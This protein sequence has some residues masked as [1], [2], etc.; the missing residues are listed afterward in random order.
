MLRQ[1]QPRKHDNGHLD[2]IRS[3]P[4]LICGNNIE[5]EACHIKMADLSI[6]KIATGIAHK[7]DDKYTVPMCGNCHRGQHSKSER[8]FWIESRI[9]P[10]KTAL[11]LFSI[12]GDYEAGIQIVT[13]ATNY[14]N[15]T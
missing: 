15:L 2:F 3:L 13:A 8:A 7:P 5:T 1:R 10:I 6:G 4:C 11:A 14:R 9:D 12:S